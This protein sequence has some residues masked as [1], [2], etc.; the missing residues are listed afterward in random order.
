[1]LCTVS[2]AVLALVAVT[3]PASASVPEANTAKFCK[4]LK[5]ISKKLE[6]AAS[7][8]S[9]YSPNVFKK[10]A[11][12]LRASSKNAPGKVKKAG[13]SLASFYGALGGGDPT[14]FAKINSTK[15]SSAIGTYFGY[16]A[17]HCRT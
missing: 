13:N 17:I 6:A 10:F 1:M 15:M 14:A 7:N 12:A 16:V 4:P 5:G 2:L 9:K 8:S 3:V 11:A